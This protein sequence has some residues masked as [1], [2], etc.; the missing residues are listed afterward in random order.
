MTKAKRIIHPFAEHLYGCTPAFRCD[1]CKMFG[2]IEQKLTPDEY[3]ALVTK[4]H[5]RTV[6]L[7]AGK[8]KQMDLAVHERFL[9]ELKAAIREISGHVFWFTEHGPG[10]RAHH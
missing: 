6:E 10:L 9:S 1:Y 3:K 7:P 2:H 4:M 5:R 8:Q